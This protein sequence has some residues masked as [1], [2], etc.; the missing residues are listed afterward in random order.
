MEKQRREELASFLVSRRNRLSP[1]DFGITVNSRRR[2]TG[3]R[4][5]EVAHHAGISATWYVRLEQGRDVRASAHT[6]RSIAKALRLSPAEQAY[7]MGL[8]RPDLVGKRLTYAV[9]QPSPN[10]LSLLRGLAPHAAYVLDRYW[11]VA[12]MN[13]P[14]V[15]LLGAFHDNDPWGASLIGRLFLD[16]GWRSLFQDWNEVARSAVAQFRLSAANQPDDPVF[17]SAIAELEAA[18]EEFRDMWNGLEILEPPIW[19]KTLL[20]PAEKPVTFDFASLRA[21]GEDSEFWISIY[22][23]VH[24]GGASA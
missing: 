18:S 15:E 24:Q 21:G 22:T 16:P 20:L 5:E 11:H 13:G 1:S 8:A 17:A 6:L 2:A 10:L 7:L 9:R 23:R 12:A 4:R 14:A 3:L 19:R